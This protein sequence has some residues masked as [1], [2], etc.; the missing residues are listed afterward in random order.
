MKTS[1]LEELIDVCGEAS[2]F[3]CEPLS[4]KLT[5][6][7]DKFLEEYAFDLIR[8]AKAVEAEK[9]LRGTL[10]SGALSV[11][12]ALQNLVNETK[13]IEMVLSNGQTTRSAT[14]FMRDQS[15]KQSAV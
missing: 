15:E 5:A 9:K 4:G 2:E 14:K 8:H 1:T 3:L 7:V 12:Q 11:K 10:P 6:T 13:D